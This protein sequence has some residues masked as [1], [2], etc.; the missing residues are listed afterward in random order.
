[1]GT[2]KPDSRQEIINYM[3]TCICKVA[4]VVERMTNISSQNTTLEKLFLLELMQLTV[5]K[6]MQGVWIETSATICCVIL[7]IYNHSDISHELAPK[8]VSTKWQSTGLVIQRMRVRFPPG[9]PWSCIFRNWSRFGSYN[10][11]RY[12]FTKLPTYNFD[13]YIFTVGFLQSVKVLF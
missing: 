4:K 5:W 13:S 6:T 10:V 2:V 7:T 12:I 1:M 3:V 9:R 11:Y 8:L